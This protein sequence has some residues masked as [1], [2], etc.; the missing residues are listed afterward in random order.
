MYFICWEGATAT[1]G[2]FVKEL[3]PLVEG[4]AAEE[5][6]T[7]GL[8]TGLL[9]I[10]PYQLEETIGHYSAGKHL[11][12]NF[13]LPFTGDSR[14]ELSAKAEL[15]SENNLIAEAIQSISK[16]SFEE[17]QHIS[18]REK[19]IRLLQSCPTWTQLDATKQNRARL[20]LQG[21]S[22]LHLVRFSSLLSSTLL[23]YPNKF[24][25]FRFTLTS[26]NS[27]CGPC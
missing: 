24:S 20:E 26:V 13:S 4:S 5:G 21:M 18:H 12:E 3:Q 23:M 22:M 14:D 6:I 15:E 2:A 9:P 11:L 7:H 10:N 19:S 17:N 16:P 27:S 1:K 8:V 25:P